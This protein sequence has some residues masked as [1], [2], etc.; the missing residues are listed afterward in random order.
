MFQIATDRN[1][2]NNI[3]TKE[4]DDSDKTSERV[5]S[6]VLSYSSQYYWTVS[7]FDSAGMLSS[8][9][10][11]APF[12]TGPPPKPTVSISA[13][14]SSAGEPANNGYFTVSRT[15]STSGDLRV[16]YSTSGTATKGSDY[17]QLPGSVTIRS[18]DSS[19]L[20]SVVPIDDT[21]VEGT[22][23]AKVTLNSR[24]AYN[25]DSSHDDATVSISDNEKRP[26]HMRITGPTSV[27][28]SS[29]TNYTA[30]LYYDDGSSSNVTGSASW[31]ESS[32]YISSIAG[33]LLQAGSV[34]SDKSGQ[35][36]RATYQ[37]KSDDHTVTITNATNILTSLLVS[38]PTPVNE[39]SSANYFARAYYNDGSNADVTSSASW[40]ENSSYASISG[41]GRLATFS[42]LSDKSCRITAAYG[43]K[44]DTHDITI[45]NV[46][47]GG[48]GVISAQ[49]VPYTQ[50]FSSGK[51]A[52]SSGWE[53]YS[54]NAQGRIAVTSGQLRM[55][56]ATG[57]SIYTLN[58]AVLHVNLAGMSNVVLKLDQVDSGDEET[59]LP[60]SFTG[61]RNGDGIAIS[62]NGT[63]WYRLTNLGSSFT[64]RSFNLDPVIQA[65]GINY[66]SD[67]RIK[68]QQYDNYPW[69]SDGRGF[70]N[71]TV[72]GNR[73]PIWSPPPSDQPMSHAQN[74]LTVNLNAVDPDGGAPSY[75]A[76]KVKNYGGSALKKKLRLSKYISVWNNERGWGE[77]YLK[78]AGKTFY[79]LPSGEVYRWNNVEAKHGNIPVGTVS[80]ACYA[81]PIKWLRMKSD[82]PGSLKST[83]AI[84]VTNTGNQ[85]LVNPNH[86][87]TGSFY[88]RVT[89]SDTAATIYDSFRVTVTNNRP[90]LLN[91]SAIVKQRNQTPF[92]INPLATD[93]DGDTVRCTADATPIEGAYAVKQRLRLRSHVKGYDNLRGWG[94]KYMRNIW[95]KL[96]YVTTDGAIYKWNGVNQEHGNI[97]VGAV[98]A[99]YHRNPNAWLRLK[100]GPT[101]VP[102][103]SSVKAEIVNNNELEVSWLNGFTG[104]FLVKVLATD[105]LEWVGDIFKVTVK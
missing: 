29:S 40:S 53:Y 51:P 2:N 26:S 65:A 8:K 47:G 90:V 96:Y 98:G 69:S 55:E 93:A 4:D 61:H 13:T 43:G 27:N 101:T 60:A 22:E 73:A 70:D 81:K 62:A 95:G 16:Y 21:A 19:A 100:S 3:W 82:P 74:T 37:G 99:Y 49:S 89:A 20:I 18:G 44:S 91:P 7:Y 31:S 88:V 54:S 68:F 58:E 46:G 80:K 59:S 83:D 63:T 84:S 79:I 30:T 77:K 34:T 78:N 12:D 6:G 25:I 56:D 57:D 14:D 24:S 32:S 105:G 48:G 39:S 17:A 23:T 67:F 5:P 64:G 50:D 103:K 87:F 94:E 41:S 33:G 28:E 75:S 66:N 72:Q 9:A 42:V 1:F 36:I 76:V 11:P 92:K 86:T 71:I 10:V 102:D 104:P 85:V 97:L 52:G 35:I 38:G 45:K 15:G